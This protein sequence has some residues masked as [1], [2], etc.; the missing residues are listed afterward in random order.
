MDK[1]CIKNLYLLIKEK[2]LD[3]QIV[4]K[5]N[6]GLYHDKLAVLTDHDDNVIAC[7]GSNN[8]SSGGYNDNYEKIRIYLVL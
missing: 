5:K 4:K 3:I 6:G 7:V 1:E 2:I 8:E